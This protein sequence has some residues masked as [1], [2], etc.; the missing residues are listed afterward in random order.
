MLNIEKNK[1]ILVLGL[2]KTGT[3][4]IKFLEKKGCNII[5]TDDF[6]DTVEKVASSC[7]NLKILFKNISD[8]ELSGIDYVLV[9]PG[10]RSIYNPHPLLSEAKNKGVAIISDLD[11]LQF[12]Y[13]KAKYIGITG[14]AGKSTTVT[15]L[16]HIFNCAGKK[17]VLIGNIGTSMLSDAEMNA[18]YFIIE[19]SSYQLELSHQIKMDY[20]VILNIHPHHLTYHGNL[21]NYTNAKEKI[22]GNKSSN[23]VNW[24]D[25][26]LRSR[27]RR[28]KHIGD[29]IHL[30]SIAKKLTSGYS[31][32]DN[33]VYKDGTELCKNI[34]YPDELN[35]D[36][37]KSNLIVA[38]AIADMI[39][40]PCK[41]IVDSLL[42]YEK[43]H[44]RMELVKKINNIEFI[45]DSK[46]TQLFST[47]SAVNCCDKVILIIGGKMDDDNP[48][49]ICNLVKS[50]KNIEKFM[51]IGE[52]TDDMATQLAKIH[53]QE[54][55]NFY[56]CYDLD[57]ATRQ[58][59]EE[60][61][62]F[63][64]SSD[65]KC[66]I[67]LSPMRQSFD[68]YADFEK[69]GDRFRSIVENLS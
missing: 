13:P 67:L 69:R 16:C 9:S 63:T 43:L 40:I 44:H 24:D 30:F 32:I 1:N 27:Y 31:L 49:D 17:S 42:S 11:I 64:D 3:A 22:F 57:V 29:K 48:D 37:N 59:Y 7:K 36:H 18:D 4:A 55:I 58:A 23:I 56:K 20:G 60:A 65:F 45:N 6:S 46:S 2:G 47:I 15:I 62:K 14:S 34:Y 52:S 10:I 21:Q 8:V 68:Q 38:I 61:V 33:I 51:L 50:T 19:L 12:F 28:Y 35:G 66:T 25:K 53:L 41:T 5:A 26:Y 54:G 39:G